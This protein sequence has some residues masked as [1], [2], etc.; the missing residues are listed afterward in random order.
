MSLKDRPL[1]CPVG[2]AHTLRS[3]VVL[4]CSQ[5]STQ[6]LTTLGLTCSRSPEPKHKLRTTSYIKRQIVGKAQEFGFLNQRASDRS[7][8]EMARWVLC[9]W[10]RPH[11]G[12]RAVLQPRLC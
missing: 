11:T 10:T 2:A 9:L 4:V 6:V 5:N 1:R 7:T 8:T 12:P 3:P